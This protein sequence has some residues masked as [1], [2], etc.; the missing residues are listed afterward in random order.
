M[1]N[2]SE[3]N[4]IS[5][6]IDGKHQVDSLLKTVLEDKLQ[7]KLRYLRIQKIGDN[8]YLLGDKEQT[9]V[10]MCVVTNDES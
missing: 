4:K 1:N 6:D 2:W 5:A 10:E 8:F 7:T 3:Q 9:K